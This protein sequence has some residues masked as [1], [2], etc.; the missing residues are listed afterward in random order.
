MEALLL[1]RA[2][3]RG[4]I[5]DAYVTADPVIA[6]P[7]IAQETRMVIPAFFSLIYSQISQNPIV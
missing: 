3:C 1:D 5:E 6:D 4:G 2:R 7:V